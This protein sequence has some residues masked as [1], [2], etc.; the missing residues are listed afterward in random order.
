[1][2]RALLANG[3]LKQMV[4]DVWSRPGPLSKLLPCGLARVRQR[5]HPEIPAERVTSFNLQALAQ[6]LRWRFRQ[7][8][9]WDQIMARNDWFQDRAIFQLE[10]LQRELSRFD[11]GGSPV[12]FSYS[13]AARKLF[14]FAKDHGWRTVL[15]QI[16]PGPVEERLVAAE[17]RRRSDLQTH[18]SPAPPPY[19]AMWR[20]EC[21]LADHIVVN[22]AW[23]RAALVE[24]KIAPEKI[25]IIPL[26][27]NA[28]AESVGFQQIVPHRFTRDRPLRV[29]FLGQIVLRK[30]VAAILDAAR[31]LE[32]QPV[33]F[34]MVGSLGLSPT[35]VDRDR[36]NVRWCGSVTRERVHD[37]YRSSDVFLF[38]TLSDGFGLTQLEAQAWHLP[39][40]ASKNCAQV[41][42]PGVNGI[43]L[44]EVSGADVAAAVRQILDEPGKLAD[45]ARNTFLSE[46]YSLETVARQ[47]AALDSDPLPLRQS[48]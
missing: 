14:E 36:C 17:H 37:Y 32:G 5:F 28:P 42:T 20:R 39:S 38:P 26:A 25:A 1:M 23:S 46:R 8:T 41:I 34:L 19:W 12:V 33:E 40:I 2:P 43:V 16:D 21:E 44:G 4:T 29:L 6:E 3:S 31:C 45:Y 27:Y 9:E 15:G 11:D 30:G 24:E 13:Y 35:A 18:W 48:A 47:F 10:R 7:P 22:S